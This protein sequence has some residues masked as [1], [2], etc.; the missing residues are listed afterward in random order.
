MG[1]NPEI[2]A[3]QIKQVGIAVA[4]TGICNTIP[5]TKAHI[6]EGRSCQVRRCKMSTAN[7]SLIYS[8]TD[9]IKILNFI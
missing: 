4:N 2:F 5:D 8:A 6:R 1:Q 9:M 7:H 3:G